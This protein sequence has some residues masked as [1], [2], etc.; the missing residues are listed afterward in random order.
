MVWERGCTSLVPYR[1]LKMKKQFSIFYTCILLMGCSPK[2]IKVEEEPKQATNS[3]SQSQVEP[4]GNLTG[5]KVDLKE[6]LVNEIYYLATES[7][8]CLISS[9]PIHNQVLIVYK[10][11]SDSE[12]KFSYI[13]PKI[14]ESKNSCIDELS[15]TAR[16]FKYFYQVDENKGD[17]S[18]GYGFELEP[19]QIIYQG[20]QIKGIDL[21]ANQQPNQLTECF[22]REGSHFN[23]WQKQG[24][25]RKKLLHRYSYLDMD[26]EANCNPN[27]YELG[28]FNTATS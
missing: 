21:L 19:K 5:K 3:V 28:M 13:K 24:S 9:S 8:S 22:S 18:T 1:S 15:S 23:I 11:D 6:Q 25:D 20:A 17:F 26:I 2:D 7:G 10:N 12:F 27:E 14:L 4:V 16:D